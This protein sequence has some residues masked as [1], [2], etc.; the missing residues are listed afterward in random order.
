MG[1]LQRFRACAR[2]LQWFRAIY[3]NSGSCKEFGLHT[4][5]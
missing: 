3:L 4:A 2:V 1:V 5:F